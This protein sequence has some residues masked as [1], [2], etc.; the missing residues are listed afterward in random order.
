VAIGAEGSVIQVA[1]TSAGTRV[2]TGSVEKPPPAW[3]IALGQFGERVSKAFLLFA[4]FGALV[5]VI[6]GGLG[7]SIGLPTLFRDD[8]DLRKH[9][10]FEGWILNS[11]ALCGHAA[12]TVLLMVIWDGIDVYE[13]LVSHLRRPGV[14]PGSRSLKQRGVFIAA[15]GAPFLVAL[16]VAAAWPPFHG[17]AL[18]IELT[19]AIAGIVV[20]AILGAAALVSV[21]WLRGVLVARLGENRVALFIVAKLRWLAL[22]RGDGK[23]SSEVVDDFWVFLSSIFVLV[24]L[25]VVWQVI[26]PAVAIVT[27]AVFVVTVYFFVLYVRPALRVPLLVI[28]LC[29]LGYFV[30][31]P[32][33]EG[34]RERFPGLGN[35]G[36]HDYLA[37]PVRLS[38]P[39]TEPPDSIEPEAALDRWAALKYW[40][41]GT[42][43]KLVI[44]SVSGGA[45]RAGFWTAKVLDRIVHESGR[46]AQLAELP[47]SIRL[48]TGASG[49]M[50]ASAYLA[51]L[52]PP[53]DE[54]APRWPSI[55]GALLGD[56]HANRGRDG[57]GKFGTYF[58]I[59]RD[60]L[61]P[62]AQQLVQRDIVR[63]MFAPLL[64][65]NPL[66]DWDRWSDRGAVLEEQWRSLRKTFA[67]LARGE[68]DGSRP[69]I[70]LS[71]MMVESGQPLLI[72]N[73]DL[74]QLVAENHAIEFFSLFPDARASFRLQTA[75]RMN[76]SFPYVSPAVA[77]P[78]VPPRRVVDAGYYDNYGVSVAASYLALPNVRKWISEN[79]D[80]VIVIQVRAYASKKADEVASPK[81]VGAAAEFLTSPPSA[82]FAARDSSMVFRN[83]EQLSAVGSL[84][85]RDSHQRE[86]VQ[87]CVFENAAEANIEPGEDPAKHA[88]KP[89]SV[90]MSWYVTPRSINEMSDQL[91]TPQ[92]KEALQCVIDAWTGK[93][94]ENGATVRAKPGRLKQ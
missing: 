90:E 73:L 89:P 60:G 80:R 55:E 1:D 41:K 10:F 30:G 37:Q 78:T 32:R 64:S 33:R 85:P 25:V 26:V 13:R 70:I 23:F 81:G 87:T 3:R 84:Y 21:E 43:R 44:V 72:S 16:L 52:A 61:S 76:A 88:T 79:V 9:S 91:T 35:D 38:D 71:P 46:N 27:L 24:G 86:L 59:E 68:R 93:T 62:V 17:V 28:Y 36:A 22:P 20:G 58:P 92:N 94:P 14:D 15:N 69:S 77:L 54:E 7:E 48:L 39:R 31:A 34:F 6:A 49:G 45:Y 83:A 53:A 74:H 19:E 56:I 67:D 12:A 2:P 40:P 75:V 42:R 82:L 5:V 11:P 29:A 47:R 18:V 66:G 65:W 4:I 63:Y 50:V 8:P 51:A 57:G